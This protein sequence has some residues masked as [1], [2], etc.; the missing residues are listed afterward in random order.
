MRGSL[1]SVAVAT[2][3]Y[4]PGPRLDQDVFGHTGFIRAVNNAR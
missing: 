3:P 2:I 4:G 1:F